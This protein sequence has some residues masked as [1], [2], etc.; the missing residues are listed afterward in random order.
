MIHNLAYNL[1]WMTLQ[2]PFINKITLFFYIQFS[3]YQREKNFW[4]QKSLCKSVMIY[5]PRFSNILSELH[6]RDIHVALL[7]RGIFDYL[8]SK[9]LA[10][11]KSKSSFFQEFA[12]EKY[13]PYKKER[14]HFFN[15]CKFVIKILGKTFPTKTII[16]PKYNDDFTLELIKAFDSLSW[17]TIV[18]DREGTVNENRLRKVPPIVAKMAVNCNYLI[19]YNDRHKMFFDRVFKLSDLKKPVIK[20]IGNPASDEWFNR[21]VP[22]NSFDKLILKNNIISF[23][24]F[25]EFSYVYDS[26]YLKGKREVWKSLL[27]EIHNVLSNHLDSNKEKK[28]LYKRGPKGNRDYWHGSLDLLTRSN[29]ELMLNTANSNQIILNSD[30]IIAFQTTVIIDAMHTDKIII[31]C[32]WGENYN[33]IKHEMLDFES[34]AEMGA[35]LHAKSAKD[36]KN[37]L[38]INPK[39]IKINFKARKEIRELFTNN[40]DGSV[41]SRFV[42]WFEKECLK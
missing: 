9:Y 21:F 4:I 23:F 42:N 16:L 40:P 27:T 35:I 36:L 2:I 22:K 20:I 10:V 6:K 33:E 25:G 28:I 39:N 32:A 14:L 18:Y 5:E 31:Y 24:A 41:A 12:L 30:I 1:L 13:F 19:T 8:F 17:K 3:R 7:P 38:E 26:D 37:Y 34:Y 11:Y 15:A 29:A